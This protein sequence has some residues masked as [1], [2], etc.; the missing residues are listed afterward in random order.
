MNQDELSRVYS[1]IFNNQLKLEDNVKQLQANIRYR[2]IDILD[3]IELACALQELET[4]KE[5][6]KDIRILLNLGGNL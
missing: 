3:C 2:K 1:Y 4:F 5:V 6:T